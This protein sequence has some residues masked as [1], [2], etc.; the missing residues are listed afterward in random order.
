[1][2][3]IYNYFLSDFF[4]YFVENR[5]IFYNDPQLFGSQKTLDAIVDDVSCLLKVP[6]RSLH[7]VHFLAHMH[8][9][10][11]CFQT[12]LVWIYNTF[13]I[14]LET[15]FCFQFLSYFLKS[16]ILRH[17]AEFDWL[18]ILYTVHK[19]YQCCWLFKHNEGQETK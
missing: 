15:T 17:L 14:I 11:E 12:L 16:W 2:I 4:I 13:R 6:R 18:L 19:I 7:V 1:M 5:E 3:E 9:L 10:L 8:T